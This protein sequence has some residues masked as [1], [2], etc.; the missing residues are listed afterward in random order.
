[1]RRRGCKEKSIKE[2]CKS[3]AR[4]CLKARVELIDDLNTPAIERALGFVIDRSPRTQNK[5]LGHF[6]AFFSW[7]VRTGRHDKNPAQFITRAKEIRTRERRAFSDDELH[8][9]TTS[10]FIPEYRRVLYTIAAYTGLRR[11][12]L[13]SITWDDVDLDRE[14]ITIRAENSKNSKAFTIPLNSEAAAIW[15]QWLKDPWGS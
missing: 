12:E 10:E 8:R 1:M 14:E 7:L 2:C 3:I 11:K 4:V 15:K 9:L 13:K 5:Y 6:K